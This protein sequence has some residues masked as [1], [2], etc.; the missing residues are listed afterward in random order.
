MRP[1][2]LHLYVTCSAIAEVGRRGG[3]DVDDIVTEG[4]KMK[5]ELAGGIYICMR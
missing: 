4:N 5:L 1:G 3:E 2:G